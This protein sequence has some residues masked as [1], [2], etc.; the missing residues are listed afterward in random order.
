M[1]GDEFRLYYG[2]A[3]LNL[4]ATLTGRRR[5]PLVERLT[6]PRRLA[7]WLAAV[8]LSPRRAPN[9][10][11]VAAAIELRGALFELAQAA[12]GRRRPD[13]GAVRVVNRA[14]A[15]D[16]P[17]LLRVRRGELGASQPATAAQALGRIARQAA[18]HLSGP[19]RSRLRACADP[20]CAGVYLD[21]SGRR[22]WC[23]DATCGVR[24]R[25]RAHRARVQPTGQGNMP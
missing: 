18:E 5:P 10:A 13:A 12:V 2:A 14:L 24:S 11:N 21:E 25:V 3:W 1:D 4:C 6:S 15:D 19:E 17:P 9:D 8:G 7:Q 22:R 23:S 16:A 20:T